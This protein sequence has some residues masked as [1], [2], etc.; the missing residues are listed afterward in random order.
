MI[1]VDVCG[2]GLVVFLI[3]YDLDFLLSMYFSQ[4]VPAE[5]VCGAPG[6]CPTSAG[7]Q[8]TTGSSVSLCQSHVAPC[9]I[10]RQQLHPRFKRGFCLANFL[11]KTRQEGVEILVCQGLSLSSDH[12]S[13]RTKGQMG[14]GKG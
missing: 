10:E 9:K 1:V 2:L 13:E 4:G 5:M 14:T 7:S 12:S 8:L 6:A 11:S 3:G